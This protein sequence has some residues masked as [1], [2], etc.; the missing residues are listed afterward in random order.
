MNKKIILKGDIDVWYFKYGISNILSLLRVKSKLLV[1]YS[2]TNGNGDI[3]K[4]VPGRG[5]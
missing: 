3:K 1:E 2:G 4:Y 5:I